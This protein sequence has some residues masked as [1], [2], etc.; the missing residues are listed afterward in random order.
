MPR[1]DKPFEYNRNFNYDFFNNNDSPL[2][3]ISNILDYYKSGWTYN[4]PTN[5]LIK[6]HIADFKSIKC[7]VSVFNT[8]KFSI[9]ANTLKESLPGT[10]FMD[11]LFEPEQDALN[12][13]A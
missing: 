9:F 4:N 2:N 13:L 7:A 12:F 1:A 3:V 6:D 5:I 8:T 11:R 10:T